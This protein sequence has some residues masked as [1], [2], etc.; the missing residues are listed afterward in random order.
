M[1]AKCHLYKAPQ[2]TW[3]P[4]GVYQE[5]ILFHFIFYFFVLFAIEIFF[6]LTHFRDW[7]S[8]SRGRG[9]RR[10]RSR[11]PAKWSSLEGGPSEQVRGA[12]SPGLEFPEFT[13]QPTGESHG[14]LRMVKSPNKA[15]DQKQTAEK[16][17]AIT[18]KNLRTG[19][20]LEES[21]NSPS[22]LL[23]LRQHHSLV[24]LF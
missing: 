10:E 2:T 20:D 5:I 9:R 21:W 18:S 24:V 12:I 6:F 1:G 14:E 3:T 7:E 22:S 4:K 11:L 19:S 8:T 23:R 17:R 15:L 16:D 13:G